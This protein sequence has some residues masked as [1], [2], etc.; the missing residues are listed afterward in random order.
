MMSTT[1]TGENKKDLPNPLKGFEHVNRYWDRRLDLPA[2][3][4]MPG[5]CYVSDKGEMIV[6]VLGSCV[7]ACIRDT[8]LGIGGMNHFM[9]PVQAGERMIDRPSLV[10][11]ALCY[12]NWAMEY[13]I[14]EI[15]KRGGL[16]SRF[17][18]KIFGGGKVLSGLNNMDIGA[19]NVGFIVDYL[20]EE[21]L[22]IAA[23]DTGSDC[24]RKVLYFPDTGAIKMKRLKTRANKTMEK[25]E[26]EYLDSMAKSQKTGDVELF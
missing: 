11:A 8:K 26:K 7:A 23:R 25:R 14:N 21:G 15:V 1:T 13:L 3:K 17:E 9:L 18:V 22:N 12:G 16:R 4:I 24:P 6:T 5:E 2:A 19:R 20:R 10:N